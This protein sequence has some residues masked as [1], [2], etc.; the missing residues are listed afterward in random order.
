MNSGKQESSEEQS[1]Q[2]PL[3]LLP[4]IIIVIL[5]WLIRFGLPAAMPGDQSLM[6]GVFAGILGGLAVAIWWAFFSRAPRAERWGAILL[7]IVALFAASRLLHV[8]I[9]TSNMGMMFVIFSVPVMS[10]AFVIWALATSRVSTRLRRILM[11]VTVICAAG[12]WTLLQTEGM[13]SN[14]HFKFAWRWAETEEERFLDQKL[15]SLW[16]CLI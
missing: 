6:I 11:V 10:L 4:G 7:M 3:R 13:T 16:L 5:Q 14:L 9:A 2:L 1:R 15:M 8:S 12:V